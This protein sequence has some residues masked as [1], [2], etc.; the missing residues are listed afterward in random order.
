MPFAVSIDPF[1]IWLGVVLGGFVA[2]LLVGSRWGKEEDGTID[3]QSW[4]G[5]WLGFVGSIV[6]GVAALLA[7]LLT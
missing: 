7:W 6:G 4:I 1:S 5:G 3:V 2:L